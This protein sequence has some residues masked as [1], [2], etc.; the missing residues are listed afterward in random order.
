MTPL[1]LR[2]VK[3]KF[4]RHEAWAL[5]T[6]MKFPF[7]AIFSFA[8]L[9]PWVCVPALV[10]APM[11]IFAVETGGV[12]GAILGF[13]LGLGGLF[14]VGLWFFPWCFICIGLMFGHPRMAQRKADEIAARLA[15]NLG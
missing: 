12:V 2:T 4:L 10:L 6:A 1:A 15:C 8:T 7:F 5:R 14:F 13:S 3:T 11:F 9:W